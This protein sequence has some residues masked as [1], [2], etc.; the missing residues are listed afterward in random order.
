MIQI[1]F[2]NSNLY[3]QYQKEHAEDFH[4]IT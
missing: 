2:I 4:F 1:K 3:T